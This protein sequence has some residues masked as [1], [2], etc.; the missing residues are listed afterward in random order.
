MV[1]DKLTLS[2][3]LPF[4]LLRNKKKKTYFDNVNIILGPVI[5]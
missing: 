4:F 5:T 3:Y 2:S 1:P